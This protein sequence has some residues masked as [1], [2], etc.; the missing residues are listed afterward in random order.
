MEDFRRSCFGDTIRS[1]FWTY[2]LRDKHPVAMWNWQLDWP[3]YQ[4]KISLFFFCNN[5]CLKSVLPNASITTRALFWFLFAWYIFSILL[6]F[7]Y[8]CL[9][10]LSESLV[11]NITGSLKNPFSQSLS[12]DRR[13]QSF[14]FDAITDKVGFK[15]GIHGELLWSCCFQD[16]FLVF[17]F[18]QFDWC[19]EV[20][21]SLSL[22][23]LEFLEL[24]RLVG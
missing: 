7:T 3:F 22:S 9:C 13:H 6:F 2:W 19:I 10:I 15:V 4:H 1:S 23:Y 24:L 16:F 17:V 14:A 8:L 5:F 18:W 12:F 11:D 21:I 20:Y